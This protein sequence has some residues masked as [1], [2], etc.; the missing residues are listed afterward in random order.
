MSDNNSN[1]DR[2][3]YVP[4]ENSNSRDN[5]IYDKLAESRFDAD[6]AK[7]AE[8]AAIG[9]LDDNVDIT[10]PNYDESKT[11]LIEQELNANQK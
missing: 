5:S 7:I 10:A 1:Q 6:S 9:T 4:L 11:E 3:R 8:E 2:E